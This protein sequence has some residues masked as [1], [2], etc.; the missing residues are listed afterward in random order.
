M[1]RFLKNNEIN[2]VAWDTC[3]NASVQGLIYAQSWYL[4]LVSPG[5]CALAEEDYS[6]VMPLPVKKKYGIPYLMQPLYAQQLGVFSPSP[7]TADELKT[8][9]SAIPDQYRYVAL[10]LN[11]LNETRDAGFPVRMNNNYLLSLENE[12]LQ[13]EAAYSANTRRNLQKAFGLNI[14]FD[15]S[16]DELIS[17]K[18]VNTAKGR[19]RVDP[20]FVKTFISTALEKGAGFIC[21]ARA[22][23][24]AVAS[25]F[26]LHYRSRIY[27]LI[28]VSDQEG[29]EKKAMFA[30]V[31][32]IIQKFSG[33]RLV[34]DFE[35]SN[36]PGLARFFEGF[37]AVNDPYPSL[38]I[39][40]LPFPFNKFRIS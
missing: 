13:T 3:I 11:S 38:R 19:R 7:V 22:G 5:W 24:K 25:V 10:N 2:R 12:Y 27:Y 6:R 37:G 15:G 32:I 1:I 31:D 35:G 4:D 36:I 14:R 21:T 39:N 18:S 8:W 20:G 29:K 30:I 23:E 34:L 33:S 26:F 9:I 40:R 16:A 28:P 17:L